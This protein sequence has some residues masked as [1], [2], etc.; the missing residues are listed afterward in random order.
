MEVGGQIHAP[1]ALPVGKESGTHCIGGWV[2]SG[3]VIGFYPETDEHSFNLYT[4]SV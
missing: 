2:G 3:A 4:L 1:A